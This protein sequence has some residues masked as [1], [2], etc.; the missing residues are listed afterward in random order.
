MALVISYA[1]SGVTKD[2]LTAYRSHANKYLEV[3]AAHKLVAKPV[4]LIPVA[5]LY[6]QHVVH[7]KKS[8]NSLSGMTSGL[9]HVARLERW[10]GVDAGHLLTETQLTTLSDLRKGL[11]KHHPPADHSRLPITAVMLRSMHPLVFDSLAAKSAYQTHEREMHWLYMLC[12]HQGVL[13]ASEARDL[14]WNNVHF[15]RS[16]SGTLRYVRLDLFHTKTSDAHSDPLP[17]FIV[18]RSDTLDACNLLQK[19]AATAKPAQRVFADARARAWTSEYVNAFIRFY[20]KLLLPGISETDL[21]RYSQYSL[22]HGGTTDLLDAKVPFDLV[23][24]QGRWKSAAWTHYRH[25][26]DAIVHYLPLV[27]AVATVVLPTRALLST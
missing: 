25:A 18:P 26:S 22:R 12:C 23:M 10:G 19:H 8:V 5:L 9:L 13:R 16:S 24:Q 3:C 14:T 6:I 20:V 2:T 4:S 27:G 15:F 1:E 11:A 21:L 17:V 7:E